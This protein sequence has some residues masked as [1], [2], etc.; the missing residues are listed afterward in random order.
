MAKKKKQTK[1]KKHADYGPIEKLQ[2]GEYIEIETT[3]AGVKAIKNTTHDPIAFYQKKKL[4]TNLQYQAAEIFA[5]DYR[6]AALTSYYA[7]SKYNHVSGGDVPFEVLET[8]Q[9]AKQRVRNALSHIGSPLDQLIQFVCGDGY[10]AGKWKKVAKSN[11]PDKDGMVALRL[12]LD[13]LIDY[14]QI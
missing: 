5:H 2:H 7:H 4:I 8:V 1:K 6:K 3:S 9:S 11:R 12:A 14:Y 10:P 13:S